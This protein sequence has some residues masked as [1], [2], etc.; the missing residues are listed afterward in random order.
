M[1]IIYCAIWAN[2]IQ[3]KKAIIPYVILGLFA[4]MGIKMRTTVAIGL[5]AIIIVMIENI[6]TKKANP[7]REIVGILCIVLGMMPSIFL[8][9]LLDLHFQ[10][11]L[12]PDKNF[13]SR[14]GL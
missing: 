14:I 6:I 1:A 2:E 4:H 9:K 8:W 10:I 11:I 3:T 7:K 5:I 13:L 12:D